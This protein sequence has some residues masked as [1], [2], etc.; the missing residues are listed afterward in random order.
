MTELMA[1]LL[2]DYS[3]WLLF[4]IY[5]VFLLAGVVKGFLGMGMPAVLIITLTLFIP[6]IE[7]ISLIVL[8]MLLTNV[9]QFGRSRA[10]MVTA[11]RYG[12]FAISTLVAIMAV[13]VN[14]QHYPEDMLL[15]SIGIAMV[16]FAVNT[17]FG[18][19]IRLGPNPVWQVLGGVIAGIIGG[20]SAVWSPPVVMYLIGRN[21]GKDEFIGAVGFLFMV[22]SIGLIIALGSISL[23][24]LPVA[25]Q[26]IIGLILALAGFRI[27]E[28]MRGFVDTDTFRKC[29]LA[30]FLIMG[31]RLVLISLF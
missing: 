2:P 31:T 21:V 3:G 20:L 29:V 9:F 1:L 14:I 4:Y 16:L 26:S 17:L 7:A 27:G 11:R 6:P 28:V 25:G 15:A 10:R 24:T 18:F 8:P 19:P 13:S 5:F 22:G 12:V 23:I 30:A